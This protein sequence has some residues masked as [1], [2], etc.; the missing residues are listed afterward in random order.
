MPEKKANVRCEFREDDFKRPPVSR[1]YTGALE[2]RVATLEAVL[3]KLKGASCEERDEVL[4]SM[5]L[6]DHMRSFVPQTAADLDVDDIV[7]SDAI[8][9][10]ALHETDEGTMAYH[11]PTS[12]FNS[13]LIESSSPM[14]SSTVSSQ[15]SNSLSALHTP[16]IRLCIGLFFRWQY[17]QYMFI[18]RE[19]FVQQFEQDAAVIE[20]G[21]TPLVYACCAM[22]APMSADPEMRANSA[23]FAE[24]SES[25]LRLDRLTA[26]RLAFRM[27]Q[28]LGFQRDH[29]HWD[30]SQRSS[31]TS[32]T[33]FNNELWRKLYWGCFI[34]DKLF[35][36]C[37]GRPTF[38]HDDDSDVDISE[39]LPHDPRIWNDW[40]LSHGLTFLETTG[41]AGPKMS[42]L[43]Y[44][45]VELGRIIHDI[46]STT[47]APKRKER[48]K[49]RRW[50][51]VSLNNL[52]ARLV[53]WHEALPTEMRWKKWL[54]A[55]DSVSADTTILHTMYH[56]TRICLNLPFLTYTVEREAT[57]SS[58]P[59]Q[60]SD[61]TPN[62]AHAPP[63]P[64]HFVESAKIC[65]SSADSLADIL[66][67]YRAQYTLGSAP[68]LLVYGA[69]VATNA[70][71][72]T[73]RRQRGNPDETP[74]LIKDT[75][76]PALDSYLK[77]MSIPW[78]LAGEARNK[79]RRAM[80]T[81]SGQ[82]Q[83]S[84]GQ[85][86]CSEQMAQFSAQPPVE[87]DINFT[88]LSSIDPALG[89]IAHEHHHDWYQETH[90][91]HVQPQIQQV[92]AAGSGSSPDVNFDSPVPYVW[93]PMS[94]LDG[95]AALWAATVGGDFPT[96]LD[97]SYDG[98]GFGWM[99]HQGPSMTLY[100]ETRDS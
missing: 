31:N 84:P 98:G 68:N 69:I 12:I 38:M 55:K 73:L 7:L 95:E 33:Y 20:P 50:T 57:T 17:P 45:Q 74:L 63:R 79:F 54:T 77:E 13:G 96:G 99:D 9:K 51:K 35:S 8:T 46:L 43:L 21:F 28:E 86:T 30:L 91:G 85:P 6:Q 94:V 100:D 64:S 56:S 65:E 88:D 32:P 34:A 78:A 52:N 39:P 44:Q 76:L 4:E 10:A 60:Q 11:G 1:E 19:R 16:T 80:S 36:L 97:M 87:Q 42:S 27:G 92:D 72:V 48:S 71:L 22:G 47:F 37:L 24:Y 58:D 89:T 75:A 67:R 15:L 53:A 41:P 66:H 14:A 61:G 62:E 82:D 81:W 26:P 5:T 49:A 29:S 70:L 83:A 2:S 25:L 18:D 23:P 93:D 90:H 3:A 40:L 59:K